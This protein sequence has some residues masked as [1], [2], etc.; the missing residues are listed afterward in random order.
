MLTAELMAAASTALLNFWHP[1]PGNRR[2]MLRRHSQSKL[3]ALIEHALAI[4]WAI[5]IVLAL[6]GSLISLVPGGIVVSILVVM[7][8]RHRRHTASSTKAHVALESA[9]ARP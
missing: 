6:A 8:G 4:C 7:R 2:G 5:A 3:I 1:M 9:P